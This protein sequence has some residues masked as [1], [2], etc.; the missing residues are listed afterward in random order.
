MI[1][2]PYNDEPGPAVTFDQNG[3]VT[4]QIDNL[5]VQ[6]WLG[7]TYQH[8]SV[9]LV[10]AALVKAAAGFSPF[11]FANFSSNTTAV[12][13]QEYA[14]LDSCEDPTRSPPPVCPGTKQAVFDAWW[15]LKTRLSDTNRALDLQNRV[16]TNQQTNQPT[17]SLDAFL[18][19]LGRE[20]G[21]EFYDGPQ[22]TVKLGNAECVTGHDNWT[23][24]Y[25][26]SLSN[27]S[28][29]CDV[30]AV[31]C[32]QGQE[33]GKRLRVFFEPRAIRLDYAES[34]VARSR[35]IGL[36]FHEALH[37]F[38]KLS[39]QQLQDFLGCSELID[40]RNI[41][42]YLE[43]FI[44]SVYPHAGDPRPCGYVETYRMPGWGICVR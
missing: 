14:Q 21:P 30:A 11:A 26:Y 39:D 13:Q 38:T 10:R 3:N 8:G 42:A 23:G 20:P 5:P 19:Y 25:Y 24:E 9:N 32:R 15:Y 37:G 43:Q 33:P 31:T 40:T 27:N 41:N 6:S 35:N 12:D 22:S 36:L 44:G 1:A 16:F 4:G 7:Y 29:K 18:K 17:Y 28:N 2:I 34:D